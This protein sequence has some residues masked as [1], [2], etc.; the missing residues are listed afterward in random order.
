MNKNIVSLDFE[1]RSACN[2]LKE[3][4]YRY[5]TDLTTEVICC[6]YRYSGE[7]DIYTWVPP[8]VQK[9]LGR[10]YDLAPW[11]SL[12]SD[13][14]IDDNIYQAWNSQFDRLIWQYVCT[15]EYQWPETYI[16][17]W[18]CTAS[19]ARSNGL[20]GKLENAAKALKLRAKKDVRGQ[21]LIKLLSI[22]NG[23][24]RDKPTFNEDPELL[25]EMI[26]Y[27]EQDVRVESN[28]V[29][30]L[31]PFSTH[32]LDEFHANE[33]INDRGIPI[34]IS[35][36]KK[37]VKYSSTEMNVLENQLQKITDNEI[38]RPTQY[39]RVKK[40]LLHGYN[41]IEDERGINY[42]LKKDFENFDFVHCTHGAEW[43]QCSHTESK[44]LGCNPRIS[45]QALKIM[46]I[47][48]KGERKFSLDKSIRHQLLDTYE[49]DASLLSEKAVEVI[50]L[51]D[52]AGRSSTAK[53]KKMV[54]RELDGRICGA[55]MFAGAAGTGRFS[56]VDIQPHNMLRDC[57]DD[58]DD[59][60]KNI[61]NQSDTEI[62]HTLAKMMRPT[63]KAEPGKLLHWSDWSNIEG[64][65]LPWLANTKES[66]KKLDMFR[67]QDA[68]PNEP[69][70]YEIMAQKMGLNDR[71]TGKV[72][73]LSLGFGG[74]VGA[75]LAMARNYGVSLNS[76]EIAKI[77]EMWRDLNPWAKTFW[78]RLRDAAWSA[79]TRPEKIYK[80]GRLSY[81]YTPTTHN[82]LGTL[83][84][85][86]PS[87]RLLAYVNPKFET[88]PCPWNEKESMTELTA[89]KANFKPKSGDI[90]WPRHKLWYGVLAENAT[91]GVCADI[92]RDAIVRISKQLNIVLHTHDEIV[93]EESE[94]HFNAGRTLQNLMEVNPDWA[95]SLPLVADLNTGF[96]YSK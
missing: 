40:W 28:M 36:A 45:P 55:Y 26:A 14:L 35:F 51:T 72:A 91:Q 43:G 34:D 25:K 12:E 30:I 11:E 71:Q 65:G 68:H 74:G 50:K 15:N 22:P 96:R 67:Y 70:V 20:P 87:S 84:C 59:A 56:A 41:Q 16:E 13:E 3:G 21:E 78:Y 77:I 9:I 38:E 58:F 80:A 47:Y 8:W 82:G 57:V 69:D 92:L 90:E 17:D 53:Y 7:D 54:Q 42:T 89:I 66:E 85:K 32:E 79:V 48:K 76:E 5:A 62:I 60:L 95:K 49:T 63:I 19:L 64:R 24:T 31:R 46:T 94:K 73:E 2:L 61:S 37:A 1:T 39:Q 88:V 86:L 23:G 83:W 6:S 75:F 81:F 33:H 93:I 52:L 4:A 44:A 10:D 18:I 29:K 27:C